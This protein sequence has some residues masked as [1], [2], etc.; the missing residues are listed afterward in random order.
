MMEA[1]MKAATPGE[2]HKLLNPFVGNWDVSVKMWEK[3]GADAMQSAGKATNAWAL[4][5]R[6]VEQRF[7]G[8]FMGAPMRG[9]GYTG[10]DNIKKAFV[11]TWMD[12]MSTSV[13]MTT[14]NADQE[15]KTM[16]FSGS[17]DDPMSGKP[18]PL[19]EVIRIIDAD[20][21]SM[22]MW[23]PAPDGQ[24]FKSMEITYSRTK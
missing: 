10:Y 23:N 18:I 1:W 20:H 9:I 17:M 15:G 5:G 21:H 8:Q 12:T 22:E 4:D 14:G 11:S 7:D 13:M 6:W 19:K 3:P 24:M 2:M 16:T